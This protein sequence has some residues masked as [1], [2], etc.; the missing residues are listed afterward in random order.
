MVDSGPRSVVGNEGFYQEAELTNDD[1]LYGAFI[2]NGYYYNRG[3]TLFF[4]GPDE[5][6]DKQKDDIIKLMECFTH[7][8]SAI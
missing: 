5:K 7:K 3:Y 4:V 8:P 1:R 6:M 2:S